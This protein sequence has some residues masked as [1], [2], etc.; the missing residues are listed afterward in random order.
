LPEPAVVRALKPTVAD[1]LESSARQLQYA[2]EQSQSLDEAFQKVYAAANAEQRNAVQQLETLLRSPESPEALKGG[3]RHSSYPTLAW[4]LHQTA[5]PEKSA[6]ALFGEYRRQESFRATALVALWSEFAGFL[7]YLGA[8]LAVLIV[9]VSLYAALILPQ[10]R[11]LYRGFGTDLPALTGAVFGG[12]APVFTLLMLLAVGLLFLLSWFVFL[13]R[14]RLKR[15]VPLSPRYQKLPLV[16]PV[17]LAYHQ[18]LWLSYAGLLRASGMGAAEALSLAA[19][20]V[21]L[22][23]SGRWGDTVAA[24]NE[25]PKSQVSAV[26]ADLS[27]AERLGKLDEETAFQQE[28]TVDTFLAT[29]ARCRRRSRIVL[30]VCV[31]FLVAIFVSAMYLPIFSL[32]SAI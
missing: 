21:P 30:T 22:I 14:R 3:L 26:V 29:L 7:A 20:R 25:D 2:V 11:S 23:S 16:G 19:T 15:F 17:A 13:L 24:S 10:F 27:M 31:Y 8:V 1:S 32:G 28:E 9:V 4:L 6:A 12:G 5:A 18:Y